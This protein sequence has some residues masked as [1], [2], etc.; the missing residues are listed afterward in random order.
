MMSYCYNFISLNLYQSNP[1]KRLPLYSLANKFLRVQVK[2]SIHSR[3]GVQNVGNY[4]PMFNNHI[5]LLYL[6]RIGEIN[7][8]VM[9]NI[10][11]MLIVFSYLFSGNGR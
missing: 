6:S 7:F 4:C 5:S 10:Y 2:A 3:Q 11:F 9:T 1:I 8:K